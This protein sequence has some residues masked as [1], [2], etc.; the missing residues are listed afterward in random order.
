MEQNKW[1]VNLVIFT[2]CYVKN[3]KES[4]YLKMLFKKFNEFIGIWYS[5]GS[6][7]GQF[8]KWLAITH[9]VREVCLKYDVLAI[10]SV[11]INLDGQLSKW[12]EFSGENSKS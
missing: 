9:F 10:N 5:H 3:L 11:Y 8:P 4:K 7:F 12:S 1:Y 6:K 2:F